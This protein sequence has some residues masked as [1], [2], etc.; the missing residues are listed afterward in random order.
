MKKV[1]VVL[2]VIACFVVLSFS[3]TGC[4]KIVEWMDSIAGKDKTNEQN[5]TPEVQTLATP[6]MRLDN[7]VVVWN[8]VSG[9]DQYRIKCIDKTTHE[10]L[11][12]RVILPNSF[13]PSVLSLS[14]GAYLFLVRAETTG[15]KYINSPFVAD[16]D[17]VT[18]TVEAEVSL[19]EVTVD[20]LRVDDGRI[21]CV[22]S[23]VEGA[24]VVHLRVGDATVDSRANFALLTVDATADQTVVLTVTGRA[25]YNYAAKEK[26]VSYVAASAKTA[27]SAAYDKKDA[28]FTYNEHFPREVEWDGEVL[29]QTF[30]GLLT[31]SADMLREQTVGLHYMRVVGTLSVHHVLVTVTDTR[32]MS[33]VGGSGLPIEEMDYELS[34][35]SLV[36]GLVVNA[37]TLVGV[38]YDGAALSADQYTF[39]SS[40]LVI[41]RD[42]VYGIGEG[43]HVLRVTYT[44]CQGDEHAISLTVHVSLPA[45]I[46]YDVASGQDLKLTA[47]PAGATAVIGGGISTAD[48]TFD[49]SSVT[50]KASYLA[51]L[52]ADKYAYC[53]QAPQSA[54]F[55]LQI[56]NSQSAPYDVV[57]SYDEDVTV[58]YG[59]FRC[60]CGGTQHYYQLDGAARRLTA[61]DA[62]NLGELVKSDAHT[63]TVYCPTNDRTTSYTIHPTDKAYPYLE[64][65]YEFEGR[66]PD[67]YVGSIAE[68][69]DV[70]KFLSYGGNIDYTKGEYGTSEI[71]VF[72]DDNVVKTT[73]TNAVLNM[74]LAESN[75]GYSSPYSCS[76]LL[77]GTFDS[78][79]HTCELTV[80]V[81]FNQ[82]IARSHVNGIEAAEYGDTRTLLTANATSRTTYIE[83]LTTTAKVANVQA[84]ADLPLGVKPVF[85]GVDTATTLAKAAYDA[86][87]DVCKTYVRDSMTDVQKLQVFYDY[88]ARYVTYDYYSLVWYE[89]TNNLGILEHNQYAVWHNAAV[90]TNQWNAFSDEE[91]KDVNGSTN[92]RAASAL[93]RRRAAE[94]GAKAFWTNWLATFEQFEADTMV[95]IK[96]YARNQVTSRG[97]TGTSLD[98]DIEGVCA[99]TTYA[100]MVAALD[101]LTSSAFDAYGALVGKV[102][103]CDGISDAFRIL[104][105]VEGIECVKV[106]G[107]G[108]N[109]SGSSEA[110]AW[111]K[112]EVGGV[113]YCVDAT[114]SKAADCVTHRYFMVS[115]DVL[116]ANHSEKDGDRVCVDTLATAEA[117]DY[118]RNTQVAG[119]S[120]YA[121]DT[122]EFTDAFKAMYRAGERT[123]EMYIASQPTEQQFKDAINDARLAL[124]LSGTFSYTYTYANGFALVQF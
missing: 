24:E 96:D 30:S 81:K 11:D 7:G 51:T 73:D 54:D 105:L 18:Y 104:C 4:A 91:R 31:L 84:L 37:N 42:Y 101:A 124:M 114:W 99:Q 87:L 27:E 75:A 60:D 92:Y 33:F 26:V 77:S 115:D 71:K 68:F 95:Q 83:G 57:L 41:P 70:A 108:I 113:W 118:Y 107:V 46:L 6:T 98:T 38:S 67:L 58:A 121:A 13:D 10:V 65:R 103:V 78:S 74:L 23:D 45:A 17:G 16:A 116:Q 8:A 22:W 110:H 102:A 20:V 82:Q 93:V 35:A 64:A 47:V 40:Q 79:S 106:S 62:V 21:L 34:K 3:L 48:Y 80:T 1:C 120:L 61:D 66:K 43:D 123:I 12:E 59:K 111:N 52:H 100:D 119:R 36:V 85:G 90:A 29:S 69:I 28:S 49:A 25:G 2:C 5:V 15:D 88:L 39:S 112:V 19:D 63:F 44:D 14:A 94:P 53:V 86:A 32:P 89:I 56:Y 117:Y 50:L 122:S 97:Y 9:A 55:S 76:I 109:S 72:V